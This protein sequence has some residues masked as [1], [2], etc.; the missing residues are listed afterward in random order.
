MSEIKNKINELKIRRDLLFSRL[1]SDYEKPREPRLS[2]DILTLAS[3]YCEHQC[4]IESEYSKRATEIRDIEEEIERLSNEIYFPNWNVCKMF[5]EN[6]SKSGKIESETQIK[7][8]AVFLSKIEDKLSHAKSVFDSEPS[9]PKSSDKEYEWLSR[10][11]HPYIIQHSY[12]LFVDKH[13][14]ET[15]FSAFVSLGDL[16]RERTGLK[17]D[18]CK[19]ATK[20][21]SLQDP[22]LIFSEIESE[23]GQ[24][25]QIGF[26][27]IIQGAFIGIR[28]P[29]AHSIK[30]DLTKEETI[31]YLILASLLVRRI[32]CAISNKKNEET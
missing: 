1:K 17:L 28:N 16:I 13:Y 7:K 8:A 5:M 3:L 18:G 6:M 32:I 31:E 11:L 24:N 15:V 20:A 21:F 26:M 22:Y 14:R 4:G 12:Q 27:Q 2:F 10:L 23:S 9:K 25:D 29:K 30:H 19:L